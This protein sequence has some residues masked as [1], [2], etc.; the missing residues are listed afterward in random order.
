M[1]VGYG[2]RGDADGDPRAHPPPRWAAGR[3]SDTT[4]A[5]ATNGVSDTTG[6]WATDDEPWNGSG[7]QPSVPQQRVPTDAYS[8]VRLNDLDQLIDP[9][10]L[11]QEIIRDPRPSDRRDAGGH[12]GSQDH[13]GGRGW[14]AAPAHDDP[15][16]R[17]VWSPRHRD[18]QPQQQWSEAPQAYQAPPPQADVPPWA[19]TPEPPPPWKAEYPQSDPGHTAPY[20]GDPAYQ[21][22]GG[23]Y[24]TYGGPLGTQPGGPGRVP[25]SPRPRVAPARRPTTAPAPEAADPDVEVES[26]GTYRGAVLA[27][28]V[29]C[30][31]P[32]V[33]YI[34]W[35][36]VLAG[37]ADTGCVD[38]NGRPCA[39]PRIVAW[40]DLL[41]AAPMIGVAAALSVV[42]ALILRRVTTGWR[43]TTV[44]FASAVV[45]AGVV[46]VL[47]SALASG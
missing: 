28:L 7:E 40:H 10:T 33:F 30:A 47:W 8:T 35:A 3:A 31:M 13:V 41:A 1:T 4:G 17:P 19:A 20:G 15:P 32:V 45:G 43:S 26:D 14:P 6:A 16:P 11:R 39:A 37:R 34:G 46:T 36:L 42:M 12:S 24:P 2:G 29:W 18:Q 38:D 22:F 21:R 9:I 44:G 25:V 5:W 23:D 27:A